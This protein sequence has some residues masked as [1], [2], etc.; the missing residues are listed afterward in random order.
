VRWTITITNEKQL[1]ANV[2]A[3]AKVCGWRV[4]HS[5]TSIHSPRGFP[6]LFMVRGAEFCA[7][8]LKAE[9][10]RVSDYQTAWLDALAQLPGAR[11]VGVVRPSSWF[12]GS[13]DEVLR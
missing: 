3:F 2:I 13:L 10:G 7:I 5:W 11:F 6:D 12:S 8:E 1:Q 4:Y 9:K